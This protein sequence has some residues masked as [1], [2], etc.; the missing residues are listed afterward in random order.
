VKCREK[1]VAIIK[2]IN[3]VNMVILVNLVDFA[4]L[5]DRIVKCHFLEKRE[6]SQNH[7]LSFPLNAGIQT[8]SFWILSQAENDRI[9]RFP[10]SSRQ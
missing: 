10:L 1:L 6:Y 5:N 8:I 7:Y 3:V 9:K 4:D 2:L